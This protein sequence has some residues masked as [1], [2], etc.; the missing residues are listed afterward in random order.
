MRFPDDLA[1][2]KQILTS[3]PSDQKEVRD[4]KQT[5]KTQC[6]ILA[7][8]RKIANEKQRQYHSQMKAHAD[9][10]RE[11]HPYKVGDIVKYYIRDEHK[12]D[13]K[14]KP[15]WVGPYRIEKF[16]R[17]GPAVQLRRVDKQIN[18]TRIAHCSKLKRYRQ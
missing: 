4:F 10:Q 2:Q 8:L 1:R 18:D 12:T 13:P 3:Q 6:T 14:L 9:Q 16:I 7:K 11:K 15:V 17:G 5:L